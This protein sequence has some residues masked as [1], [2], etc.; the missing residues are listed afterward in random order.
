MAETLAQK[1]CTPCRVG[2]PPLAPEEAAR[3]ASQVPNWALKSIFD[4]FDG[5]AAVK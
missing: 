2:I 5:S 1:L 4:N 3:Y